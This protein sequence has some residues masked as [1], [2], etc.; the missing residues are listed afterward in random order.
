VDRNGNGIDDALEERLASANEKLLS[1]AASAAEKAQAQRE[2]NEP[3]EV[4]A[5][6]SRQISRRALEAFARRGEVTFIYR[7]NYGFVGNA[8]LNALSEIAAQLAGEPGFEGLV[9]SL[10]MVS[11]LHVA[12]RTGRVRQ[13][14]DLGYSG[15]SN[16]TI[17]ILDTGISSD[18]TEAGGVH[19]DLS[20]RQQFWH[21]YTADGAQF[22]RDRS[23]HGSHVAGIALGSGTM[24]GVNPQTIKYTHAAFFGA[25]ASAAPG[26]TPVKIEVPTPSGG[27]GLSRFQWNATVSWGDTG[28]S[29]TRT[30]GLRFGLYQSFDDPET[31]ASDVGYF[32]LT[33]QTT[34]TSGS[35]T[36][37]STASRPTGI[38]SPFIGHSGPPV[39]G[40]VNINTSLFSNFMERAAGVDWGVPN[41]TRRYSIATTLTALN[42]HNFGIGDSHEFFRGVA[43]SC[44]WAGFKVFRDD[45]SGTSVPLNAALDDLAANAAD[46][47]IKV[48]NLSLGLSGSLQST[49][50]KAN[51][52]V[53]AGVLLVVSAGND[54]PNGSIHDPGRAGK[55]L[56]VGA[57][58]SFNQLTDYT[59]NGFS[60]GNTALGEDT[61]KPDVITVGGSRYYGMVFSIDSNDSDARDS[62]FP[63]LR[64]DDYRGFE[65][66]SM[67]APF[68]A[69]AAAL[70]IGAWQTA[71]HT[72]TFGGDADPLFVKM[73][74]LAT[75]TETNDVRE[76]N[77][78]GSDPG[79]NPPTLGRDV[80]PKDSKEGYGVLNI[81]AAIELLRRE[82]LIGEPATEGL[83][84]DRFSKRASGFSV[85][86]TQGAQ[87]TF[88]L[89]VPDAADYDLYLYSPTPGTNGNPVIVASAA[90][91]MTGGT[92]V[93]QYSAPSTGTYYLVVKRV[94]GSGA[95]SLAASN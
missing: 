83:G 55:V 32:S 13:Q 20:G 29:P 48:A 70:L 53:N 31:T 76:F 5:I 41:P 71:G 90:T 92:E 51:T 24:S 4:E 11:H 17:A 40:G 3:V 93:I 33:S 46:N 45:G 89:T 2:L 9:R 79:I 28:G 10:P 66:T 56:T 8:P 95:F 37:D 6:F 91:A 44:K 72:W 36:D 12:T 19:A 77:P 15:D 75:A 78:A 62:T 7:A 57:T 43:P 49:R 1:P 26:F 85:Q 73:L 39:P 58:N 25:G 65:G 63:D 27:T 82:L 67:A 81:D 38:A 80:A 23:E 52:A 34:D 30:A 86:L 64:A 14:W 68:A 61:I 94:S 18:G 16:I 59:T 21:D 87:E 54:G 74:L 84:D 88:T 60:N 69:G 47:N 42:G 35:F 22:P 50:D